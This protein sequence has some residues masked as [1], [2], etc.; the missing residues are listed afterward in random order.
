MGW[1]LLGIGVG[2]VVGGI[3]VYVG[4]YFYFSKAFRNF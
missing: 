2:L 4:L 1:L 3:A